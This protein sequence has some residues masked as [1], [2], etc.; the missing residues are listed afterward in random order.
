M[1]KLVSIVIPCY[2][3]SESIEELVDE[4]MVIEKK[5]NYNFEIILVN[6]CSKDNTIEKIKNLSNKYSSVIGIDL[7]FNVGQFRAVMC[8][9][10]N[11]NGDYV[12]T[13]DDDLQHPPSEVPK[14][15]D[16]IENDENIDAVFAR[17]IK[18]EHK[19]YRNLGSA[20]AG[21]ISRKIFKKPKNFT[22]SAFRILR[23]EVVDSVVAHRTMF[24]VIGPIIV[25]STSKI[26]NIDVLHKP[27]KYGISNY[28]LLK[29]IRMTFD[30]VINFSSF[31]LKVIS[32]IGIIAFGVSVIL[33][34]FY[35]IRYLI[36]GIGVAGW[37]TN[38]IL[39]NLYGGL[40]LSSIGVIGEYLIRIMY[41]VNGFPK[42]KIRKKYKKEVK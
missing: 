34:L 17:P 5:N 25:K 32:S 7:M 39:I 14:L 21:F 12:I 6:D 20:F 26:I 13:M 42:Y 19:T 18:R 16:A 10:E 40:I 1:K 2:N 3:S 24:P 23:R 9:F 8:G 35:L 22:M 41:E 33:I 29:L 38:V 4:L 36:G 11:S 31:P 30:N 28:R 27:R 37:T 15:I